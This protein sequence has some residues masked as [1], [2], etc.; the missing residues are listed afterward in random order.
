MK[1]SGGDDAVED[2]LRHVQMKAQQSSGQLGDDD[3]DDESEEAYDVTKFYKEDSC[4]ADLAR[5][6]IF[7]HLTL[8]VISINAVWMGVDMDWNHEKDLLKADKVFLV[9]ENI[10]CTY[11]TMEVMVRWLA[12]EHKCNALRDNWFRFDA[13]LVSCMILETWVIPIMSVVS[14]GSEGPPLGN[15]SILRLLRLL[16]LTRITRLMRAMPELL[17]LI[18]GMVNATRSVFSTLVLLIIATYVMAI[19]FTQ[20]LRGELDPMFSCMGM[21]MLTLFV[22]GTLLDDLTSVLKDILEANQMMMWLFVIYIILSS[23]TIL[24][25]LIG[26]LCEVV[27]SSAS[28][29]KEEQTL[30][31]VRNALAGAFRQ[32]DTDGSGM[33]SKAEF[34]K[35]TEN[36]K[37]MSA[38]NALGVNQD[39]LVS[40][41]NSLFTPIASRVSLCAQGSEEHKNAPRAS[42]VQQSD[43]QE[44]L[45]LTF[46]QFVEQVINHRPSTKANVL[47][48]AQLRSVMNQELKS[49]E[50]MIDSLSRDIQVANHFK[51]NEI[52]HVPKSESAPAVL[53]SPVLHHETTDALFE[54]LFRRNGGPSHPKHGT[55]KATQEVGR[56]A[57]LP[58]QLVGDE[59]SPG[60]HGSRIGA[61]GNSSTS[62]GGPPVLGSLAGQL[63][64]KSGKRP[65]P[66]LELQ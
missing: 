60:V 1:K 18:K 11:F 31:E 59:Q 29:E 47:D 7:E 19:V 66:A 13:G 16:R 27:S 48:C 40:M 9:A 21:S 32:I 62:H 52:N 24:N 8:G 35:L 44:S 39:H 37:A 65:K 2:A 41:R 61:A 55:Y 63:S 56:G 5:S 51:K 30:A 46:D 4:I 15:L 22:N 12:F 26:V 43:G 28:E 49:L 38:L 36:E 14:G 10:F 34:E 25:M 6:K 23:M 17:T 3:D 33:L 50:I 57:A 20:Q 42:I 54:E 53:R 64:E 45:G 58:G